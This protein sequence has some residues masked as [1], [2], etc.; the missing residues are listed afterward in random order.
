MSHGILSETM[1][2]SLFFYRNEF[3]K[4]IYTQQLN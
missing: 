4:N 3:A 2:A 1:L